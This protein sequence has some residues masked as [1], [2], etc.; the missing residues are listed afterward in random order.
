MPDYL[1]VPMGLLTA[2]ITAW[3]TAGVVFVFSPDAKI[4]SDLLAA[5]SVAMGLSGT[6][7]QTQV[8]TNPV[9]RRKPAA[10]KPKEPPVK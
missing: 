10:R 9:T 5:G 3:I 8:K 6:A 1:Y 4:S 7:Y 2:G